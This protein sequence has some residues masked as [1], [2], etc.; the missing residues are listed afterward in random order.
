MDALRS[1]ETLMILAPK[2]RRHSFMLN[3]VPATALGFFCFRPS[4]RA[5]MTWKGNN[6]SDNKL[7]F[8]WGF[9]FVTF[10]CASISHSMRMILFA[11]S[12]VFAL[13]AP[14]AFW[15][16]P[17]TISPANLEARSLF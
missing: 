8:R 16:Q 1:G 3:R 13:G 6:T 17:S 14:S 2:Q 10:S 15:I 4:R 9:I 7:H 5:S 12:L 11:R